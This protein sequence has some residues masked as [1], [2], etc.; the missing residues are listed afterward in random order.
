VLNKNNKRERERMKEM[1]K[2]GR[3]EIKSVLKVIEFATRRT[4]TMQQELA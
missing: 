3:Q 2:K 4:A 1:E